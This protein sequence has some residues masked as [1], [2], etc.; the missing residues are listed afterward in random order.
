LIVTAFHS[1]FTPV[2]A[3]LFN[4]N[5]VNAVR[6]IFKTVSK[7]SFSLTLPFG[8]LIFI[9]SDFFLGL[10]GP[11]F[12]AGST[13]LKILTVGWVTHALLGLSSSI[14][15]M[16][17]RSRLHLFNTGLFFAVN[18]V[19]NLWLIPLYGAAG[20]ALATTSSIIL[21]DVL[22]LLEVRSLLHLHP[23]TAGLLKSL[24]SGTAVFFAIRLIALTAWPINQFINTIISAAAMII[25][26]FT[27]LYILGLEQDEKELLKTF[28][29]RLVRSFK[30]GSRSHEK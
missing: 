10:F 6:P 19:L 4:K 25:V 28:R 11:G 17:G 14:L 9:F 13:A 18:I 3:D 26:Y 29:E 30:N 2:I 24:A 16:S 1:I 23:F 5:I 7:L 12:S 20:A 27:G 8:L 21:L 22:V 15:T